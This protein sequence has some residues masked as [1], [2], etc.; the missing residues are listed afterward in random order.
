[1]SKSPEFS[2]LYTLGDFRLDASERRLFRGETAVALA[3]KAFDLLLFLVEN[4]GRLLRKD[5]LL[6]AVWPDA[7]VEENNL[8][9]A[10][11]ALR[12]AFRESEG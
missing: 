8:T 10:V 6:T 11:S 12:K 9:V 5:D 7:T 4:E 1:M 3:P 2:N